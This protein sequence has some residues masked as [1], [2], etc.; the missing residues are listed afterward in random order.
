MSSSK[1]IKS[2]LEAGPGEYFFLA[3]FEGDEPPAPIP[4]DDTFRP[5]FAEFTMDSAGQMETYVSDNDEF[6]H[7]FQEYLPKPVFVE[8]PPPP[9]EPVIDIEALLAGMISEEDAQQRIDEAYDSGFSESRRQHE[10][11]LT[12]VSRAFGSAATE[13]GGLRE[14]LLKESEDDLL[15]LAIKLAERII[16]QEITLDRTILARTVAEVVQQ[17][18]DHEAVTIRF[19]PSDHQIIVENGCLGQAGIADMSR[20]EVKSDENVA[21]GGCLVE[22]TSGQVDGQ[23]EAQLTELFNQLMEERVAHT[24][25]SDY[26]EE[27]TE[28]S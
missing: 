3:E 17:M 8:P 16:R 23:I 6:Q 19:H 9:P 26:E 7:M 10:D 5:L 15:R 25:E 28:F 14:L 20:I 24:G 12:I 4:V 13:L 21:Q 2:T 27:V 11:D 22:T 1:V 18:A